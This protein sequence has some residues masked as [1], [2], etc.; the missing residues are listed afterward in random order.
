[1]KIFESRSLLSHNLAVHNHNFKFEKNQQIMKNEKAS[2]FNMG[3]LIMISCW[4]KL[5]IYSRPHDPYLF[6]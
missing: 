2:D 5:V 4:S 1:M 3:N 6:Y